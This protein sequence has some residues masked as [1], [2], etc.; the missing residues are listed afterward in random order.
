MGAGNTAACRDRANTAGRWRHRSGPGS[1]TRH[2]CRIPC[3]TNRGN[4]AGDVVEEDAAAG[5]AGVGMMLSLR[6]RRG[7]SAR[8]CR[9]RL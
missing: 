5:A 4:G 9:G 2:V 3:P 6:R 8:A 1:A 7:G